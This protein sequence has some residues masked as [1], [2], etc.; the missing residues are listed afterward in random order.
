MSKIAP[1]IINRLTQGL[2]ASKWQMNI[3]CHCKFIYSFIHVLFICLHFL[4][5]CSVP[6][7]GQI[8]GEMGMRP[9]ILSSQ[10][11]WWR[12]SGGVRRKHRSPWREAWRTWEGR[13]QR[14]QRDGAHRWTC[15]DKRESSNGKED[16]DS[17]SSFSNPACFLNIHCL[18]WIGNILGLKH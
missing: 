11:M 13:E 4:S 9:L 14:F 16:E 3:I 6:R 2:C 12:Q 10:G 1:R 7:I 15:K 17:T 5:M 18:Y 8:I